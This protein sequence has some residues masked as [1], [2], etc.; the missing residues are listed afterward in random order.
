MAPKTLFSLVKRIGWLFKSNK[1]WG[2]ETQDKLDERAQ[3][4][5][6]LWRLALQ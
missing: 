2:E 5:K 4:E 6:Y 1:V 3:A